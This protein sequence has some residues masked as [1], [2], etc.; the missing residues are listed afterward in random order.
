MQIDDQ[1]MMQAARWSS[2]VRPLGAVQLGIDLLA[3]FLGDRAPRVESA[4]G[5]HV[6]RVGR[7]PLEDLRLGLLT[8]IALR[9][10][11]DQRLGVRVLR[12]PHDLLGR[13]LL[14]DPPQ[15]HDADAVREM[16][17]RRQVVGDHQDAHPVGAQAVEQPQDAGSDGD[18]EHRHRLVG[19][20]QLGI[21]HQ[22]GGDRD[23][24]PLAAG[25]LVRI[26][27]DVQVGRRQAG[28]LHGLAHLRLA[29]LARRLDAVD[30]QRL[31]DRVAH[32]EPR[33]ERLVRILV[34]HLDVL[35]QR[36][37][38]ARP[39]SPRAPGHGSG[40]IRCRSRPSAPRSARWSSCRS[41]T[42]RPTPASRPARR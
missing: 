16:C 18:V 7:L 35:A 31:L 27:L 15:V 28:A 10:H 4:T 42:R 23:A 2:V 36:P 3:S 22:A 26:A 29:V 20:Q 9:H 25:Q 37:H 1:T 30:Q 21:E 8:R 5:R 6:H 38:V 33:V 41:R 12:I 17:R 11:R 40:S 34:D 24:L 14:D 32:R 13:P 39:Q 19:D